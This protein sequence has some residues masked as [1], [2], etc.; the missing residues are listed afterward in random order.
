M[1]PEQEARQDIDKQLEAAG[2]A[3]QDY[4]QLNLGASLGVA[5]R[6]CYRLGRYKPQVR[7]SAR[8]DWRGLGALQASASGGRLRHLTCDTGGMSISQI[9]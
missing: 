6:R 1:T 3:V 4:K 8:D 7:V 2:W 9:K 5:I